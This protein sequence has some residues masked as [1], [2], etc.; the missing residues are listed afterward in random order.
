MTDDKPGP[1]PFDF[2]EFEAELTADG[3]LI[4]TGEEALH[5][6][7]AAGQVLFSLG[8]EP[9]IAELTLEYPEFMDPESVRTMWAAA[10][11]D[12]R[13][14]EVP[15]LLDRLSDFAKVVVSKLGDY[16]LLHGMDDPEFTVYFPCHNGN[17]TL[18]LRDKDGKANLK[19]W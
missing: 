2:S 17:G 7:I 19:A 6:W 1:A 4:E 11:A 10:K 12:D 18:K 14:T 13:E 3:P 16:F 9:V 8:P 15:R 5:W